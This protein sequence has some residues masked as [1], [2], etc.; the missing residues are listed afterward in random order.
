MTIT[1]TELLGRDIN[2][3]LLVYRIVGK[4]GSTFLCSAE[5]LSF[6]KPDVITGQEH[7]TGP[8][9]SAGGEDTEAIFNAINTALPVLRLKLGRHDANQFL[10][11]DN[12]I[13][14][15][16]PIY[17]VRVATFEHD[18]APCNTEMRS[19]CQPSCAYHIDLHAPVRLNH[20]HL[21]E[22]IP[23]FAQIPHIR[24]C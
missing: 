8:S 9:V 10:V 20:Q 2:Q 19:F 14:F 18:L 4:I 5:H 21:L 1:L 3:S 6:H 23:Y 17:P 15:E 24:N 7:V 16:P 12:L 13:V 11:I 22:I